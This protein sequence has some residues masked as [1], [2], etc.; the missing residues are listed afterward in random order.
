[1]LS[2]IFLSD[3]LLLLLLHHF[4]VMVIIDLILNLNPAHINIGLAKLLLIIT[5]LHL[6]ELVSQSDLILLDLS[7]DI[8]EVL[9]LLFF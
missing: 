4:I 3:V 1:M 5:I 2:L 7:L 9:H 6:F 8:E